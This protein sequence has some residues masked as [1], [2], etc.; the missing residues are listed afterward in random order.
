MR[1]GLPFF[2]FGGLLVAACSGAHNALPGS[3]GGSGGDAALAA[4]TSL[5]DA[6]DATVNE[7]TLDGGAAADASDGDA[8]AE[9]EAD[10]ARNPCPGEIVCDDFESTAVGT[11]PNPAF[12]S[13]GAPNCTRMGTLAVDDSDAHSGKHSVKVTNA[14]TVDSGAPIY[15]DHVF[16]SNQSAFS[17]AVGLRDVYVRFFFKLADMIGNGHSTFVTMGDAAHGGS[18]VR[19]GFINQ[20]FTWNLEA[21]SGD[22]GY[23]DSYLPPMTTAGAALS[24]SPAIQ[25]TW[26]CVEFHLDETQGA[27]DTWID[28]VEVPG[29]VEPSTAPDAGSQW[30]PGWVPAVTDV[31]FGWETYMGTPMT[32]WFDD[33]AIASHRIGCE[34]PDQ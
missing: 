26:S 20:V 8:E 10:A 4:D 1:L 31:G 30:P 14:S 34:P 18:H 6:A 15:C 27:I 16:F 24:T 2:A 5:P 23:P 22:G 29:L 3:T 11:P 17:P 32:I 21:F 25:P 9:A 33:V 12:W 7:A 19:L 13:V 28:D